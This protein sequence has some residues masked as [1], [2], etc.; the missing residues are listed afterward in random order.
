MAQEGV[1]VQIT[2]FYFKIYKNCYPN[3]CFNCDISVKSRDRKVV[4]SVE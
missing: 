4:V 2:L 1:V 3:V